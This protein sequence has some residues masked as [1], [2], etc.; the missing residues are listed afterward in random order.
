MGRQE[1]DACPVAF[2]PSPAEL[3]TG[4]FDFDASRPE[5]RNRLPL[6]PVGRRELPAGP[7]ELRVTGVAL[8][9]ATAQ[10]GPGSR[11]RERD[12]TNSARAD[13]SSV[14]GDRSWV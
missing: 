4:R 10:F 7:A 14:R 6:F 1:F 13:R 9:A 3:R 5:E 12:E 2:G 11:N 8:R